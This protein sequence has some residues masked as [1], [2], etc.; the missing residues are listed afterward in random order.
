MR[1]AYGILVLAV[2]LVSMTAVSTLALQAPSKKHKVVYDAGPNSYS[3]VEATLYTT[4]CI[5]TTRHVAFNTNTTY[6]EYAHAKVETELYYEH[7]I[8]AIWHMGDYMDYST[9]A[10]GCTLTAKTFV[11]LNSENGPIDSSATALLSR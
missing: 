11:T 2:L 4:W 8:E 1:R 7:H 9:G 5:S 6:I 10:E 3:R